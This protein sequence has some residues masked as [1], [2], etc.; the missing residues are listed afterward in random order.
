MAPEEIAAVIHLVVEKSRGANAY[1]IPAAVC[2]L[3]GFGRC[4][5]D[6]KNTIDAVLENELK[7]SRLREERGLVFISE[8]AGKKSGARGQEATADSMP[9]KARRPTSLRGQSEDGQT[10]SSPGDPGYYDYLLKR[11]GSAEGEDA[12]G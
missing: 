5:S 9:F 3:L 10:S 4:S 11:Y 7:R 8:Q 2:R 6:M 1:E 12:P